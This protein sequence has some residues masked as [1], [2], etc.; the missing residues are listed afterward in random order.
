[1]RKLYPLLSVLFLIYW[2]CEE[3]TEE[4]TTQQATSELIKQLIAGLANC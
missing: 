1:M 4:D 2:S 3:I